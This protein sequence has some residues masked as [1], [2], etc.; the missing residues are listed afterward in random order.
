[1]KKPEWVTLLFQKRM[2]LILVLGIASGLPLGLTGT[3]LQAWYTTEKISIVTIGFLGLIGIPYTYKFLWAPFMDRWQIPVFHLGRRRGWMLATQ[4]GLILSLCIMSF[5]SPSQ[6]GLQLAFVALCFAFLSASQDIVIDAYRTELLTADE[7]GV[8]TA[9]A[10]SGYRIAMLISGGLT[11]VIA[12]YM[13]FSA[14]Y[15]L[16]AGMMGVGLIATLL[17]KEPQQYRTDSPRFWNAC[18]EPF[19]E[20]LTRPQ[21]ITLLAFL[22]FYKLGDAFAATLT[23]PFLIRGVGFSLLEVGIFYKSVGLVATLLGVF[24]GG[25]MLN[26]VGLFR[27]LL[28]FGIIQALTNVL[29]LLLTFVGPNYPVMIMTIF[30]ENLGGGLGTAAFMVL[31]MSLCNPQY[32][33]TQFALLSSLTAV[34]RVFVGPAAGFLVEIYGWA[35]FFVLTMIFSIP[36]LLLLWWL[37]PTIKHYE[38][39]QDK[40]QPEAAIR[41]VKASA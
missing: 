39:H 9:M 5:L 22:I 7:R 19:K 8:G 15:L 21:A 38:K 11:L 1:M 12:H 4:C 25:V 13:G 34:G 40:D 3:T 14:T 18:I 16:M 27:A 6:H 17:A 10:V 20:F 32:T 37:R 33:A 30:L 29:F 23:S 35:E 31:I 28:L 41:E 36:G 26:N 2:M 24:I